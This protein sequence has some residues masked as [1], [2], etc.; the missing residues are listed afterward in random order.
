MGFES[1]EEFVEAFN[2][3]AAQNPIKPELD[4]Q[5]VKEQIESMTKDTLDSEG[6]SL[7]ESV[8]E[9]Q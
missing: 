1:Y 9:D 3:A 5:S 8:D 4:E 6:F 7:D 2:E